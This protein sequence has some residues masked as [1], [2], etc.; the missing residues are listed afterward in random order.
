MTLHESNSTGS[1]RESLAQGIMPLLRVLDRV[2]ES[3]VHAA[4]SA[5]GGD[6]VSER[7]R[8][9]YIG[10]AEIERS[11]QLEPGAPTLPT[12][13]WDL[14]VDGCPQL[15]KLQDIYSLTLFD[16]SAL[17]VVLAPE[18]D[19]RYE[20]LYAYLQDDVTRKRPTVD[21]VLNLLSCSAEEKL[22]RRRHFSPGAPLLQHRI[23]HLFTDANSV[24]PPLLSHCLKLDEQI[25]QM[26][27]GGTG[28]DGRLLGFCRLQ[29]GLETLEDL[30]LSAD[31]KTA[32]P[33]LMQSGPARRE[34]GVRQ[35]FL[36]RGGSKAEMRRTARAA[37]SGCELP[38]LVADLSAIDRGGAGLA[39]IV[40]TVLTEA[41]LKDALPYFEGLEGGDIDSH[42]DVCRALRESA[43]AV[44]IASTRKAAYVRV[45]G[46]RVIIVN[47]PS[48]NVSG[49]QSCWEKAIGERDARIDSTTLEALAN[50]F[51]LSSEQITQA[52]EEGCASATWRVTAQ[53]V[54]SGKAMSRDP[55]PDELYAA[56]R[57]QSASD[58]SG[59]ARKLTPMYTWT[60]L[61]L[62]IE[63]QEQL[64]EICQRVKSR[65]LVMGRWGF[66]RKLSLGKG[67]SA[68][69]AGPSGTG[70]TMAAEVIA[71]DVNLD[72]FTID[73]ASVVSKYIGETEK[74]LDRI[75]AIAKDTD[76]ILFFDEADALFGKRSE[77][78]DSHDRYANLEISYL[79]QKMDA[80]EG[81]TILASNLRQHMDESFIR[82]LAITVLF[83]FPE[84]ADRNRIWRGIWPA[85][86]PL[87]KDID[88]DCLSQ[89][90]KL[91]GGNIR[92]VALA[93]AFLAA[94]NGGIVTMTHLLHAVEREFQKMGKSLRAEDRI[95]PVEPLVMT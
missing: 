47:F 59:V 50:R 65:E 49:R 69:F 25:I 17:V 43:G 52:V 70:K 93:A 87:S 2:L 39:D 85:E 83:P 31:I 42:P 75:F 84:E 73:L 62:P 60:D 28:V 15:Q 10:Q 51:R 91:S 3:A 18:V 72:L 26:L 32:L 20:R 79:L 81:V 77:V 57:T 64:R 37:A 33:R 89:R 1:G 30:S 53:G 74:N 66:E 58:L 13:G 56:A 76:A 71:N 88:F 54:A 7:F 86:T 90:F 68:L 46:I 63:T 34:A 92:N 27:L 55:L 36:F 80:Y 19:L 45:D 8:G 94:Q 6:S 41:R 4:H 35:I 48:L 61:V 44:I 67:T 24:Q 21:L 40:F 9:L 5:W 16:L 12:C 78:R 14:S 22:Q 11:L 38:I 29:R 82:R 95:A 23:M